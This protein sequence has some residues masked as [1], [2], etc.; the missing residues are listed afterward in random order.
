MIAGPNDDRASI[1]AQTVLRPSVQAGMTM[2]SLSTLKDSEDVT[3]TALVEEVRTQCDKANGGDLRR[4]EAMLMTQAHTLDAIFGE[5]ACR[6]ALNMG[7]YLNTAETY[8]RLGLKAQSQCRATL[9]TLAAIKSPAAVAFVRQANI[10]AGPQQVNNVPTPSEESRA[11]ETENPQSKL[12]E[13]Q[14]GQWLDG[15]AT[16]SASAA[17]TAL[18]TW[19][20]STGPKTAKGKARVSRN[21]YKGAARSV[22]RELGRL[23]RQRYRAAV[24]QSTDT[25][26]LHNTRG[27]R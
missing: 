23:L 8:M 3:L 18:E 24:V 16:S 10:A 26:N 12:L 17:H 2:Q 9:E 4:A 25:V 27:L 11:R 19:E 1:M 7:T 13:E 20:R 5:C 15:G 14:N 22:L 6:S 21:A